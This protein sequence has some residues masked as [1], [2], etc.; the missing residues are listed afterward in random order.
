MLI[1]TYIGIDGITIIADALSS[2]ISLKNLANISIQHGQAQITRENFIPMIAV[3]ARIE[4]R[5][6]GSTMSDVKTTMSKLNLPTGTYIEYGG[7]YQ[8]QQQSFYELLI[9]FICAVL[10]VTL[11]LLFYYE[12]ILILLS[13]LITTLLSLS[14]VFIGLWVSGI[15][16]NISSLMGMTMIIGIVTEIAIFYFSELSSYPQNNSDDIIK[17]G[18][19]RMRPIIMTTI[20]A[21]LA[22]SPLALGL[23]TGSAMHQP[24]AVA[25]I[26][27]LIFALPLVLIAMPMI[28]FSF[29]KI[30]VKKNITYMT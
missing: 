12:N 4:N 1:N 30:N 29:S 13:I 22:L 15:E 17:A 25:I 26:F 18:V 10:L 8:Q 23:G 6:L 14:G 2:N 7:I 9:V 5:D 28:Y 11:L 27:G 21:I 20:I 24:L 3:K 19:M 16:L